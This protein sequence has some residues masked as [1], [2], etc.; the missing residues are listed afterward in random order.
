MALDGCLRT[1]YVTVHGVRILLTNVLTERLVRHRPSM[2]ER[3]L[4]TSPFAVGPRARTRRRHWKNLLMWV[5]LL[6]SGLTT[7]L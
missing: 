1:C 6:F 3:K 2:L 7:L 4:L 5:V